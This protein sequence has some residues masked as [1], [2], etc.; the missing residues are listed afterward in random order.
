MEFIQVIYEVPPEI[1]AGL[2]TNSF[3]RFGSVVRGPENIIAHLKE[4]EPIK[5]SASALK[6][7]FDGGVKSPGS[8]IAIGIG[9]VGVTVG[10][11]YLVGA[12]KKSV[13]KSLQIEAVEHYNASLVSYLEAI[14]TGELD[15]LNLK[16]FRD[17][18]GALKSLSK[19]GEISVEFSQEHSKALN[20]LLA[21]YTRELAE[22]NSVDLP[23][24]PELSPGTAES[25]M[26]DIELYLDAQQAIIDKDS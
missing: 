18:V 20:A 16:K 8:L 24:L 25:L 13:G 5:E 3:Q 15:N 9:V 1:A 14:T 11:I 7:L 2:A 10:A 22:A 4:V 12:R 21:G 19:A 17:D 23:E 6:G 26:E